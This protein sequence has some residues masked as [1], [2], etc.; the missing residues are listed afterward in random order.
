MYSSVYQKSPTN[1][2]TCHDNV[3]PH[4]LIYCFR[5]LAI[6]LPVWILSKLLQIIWFLHFI[7]DVLYLKD[8]TV[9][10]T[11]PIS[12]HQ[13]NKCILLFQC[14]AFSQPLK[15][16]LLDC[17]AKKIKKKKKEREKQQHFSSISNKLFKPKI[18]RVSPAMLVFIFKNLLSHMGI[19]IFSFFFFNTRYNFYFSII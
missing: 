7:L 1:T 17:L 3:G 16:R 11:V 19:Y 5:S 10:D 2:L 4:Y 6:Q 8:N 15:K 14:K 9:E 13:H 12:I 18:W